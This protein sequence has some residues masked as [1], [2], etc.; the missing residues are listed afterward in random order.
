MAGLH[1]EDFNIG[2]AYTTIGRTY[3]GEGQLDLAESYF[4]RVV[5]LLEQ[6]DD[7]YALARAQTNLA[8]LLI[9]MR[10][11]GR[12]H[13]AADARQLLTAAETTQTLLGDQVGLMTTRHNRSILHNA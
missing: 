9:K 1:F 6:A 5:S 2:D 13:A 7:P 8:A 10:D 11:H 4:T 12:E 3:E